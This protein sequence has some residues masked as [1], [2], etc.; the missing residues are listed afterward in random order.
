M[1]SFANKIKPLLTNGFELLPEHF[2]E[3]RA[4]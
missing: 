4:G 1:T 3:N 2:G